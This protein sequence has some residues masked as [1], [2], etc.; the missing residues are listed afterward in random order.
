MISPDLFE[1][2]YFVGEK[3]LSSRD[4]FLCLRFCEQQYGLAGALGERCRAIVAQAEAITGVQ[5][6]HEETGLERPGTG[7]CANQRQVA[8]GAIDRE[9]YLMAG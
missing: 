5:R 3:I 9:R 6:D 7:G 2:P 4:F 1:L 8:R